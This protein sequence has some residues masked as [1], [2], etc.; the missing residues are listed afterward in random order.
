MQAP[1]RTDARLPVTITPDIW[2]EE[3]E[4]YAPRSPARTAADRERGNLENA[5]VRRTDLLRCDPD[6]ADGTRLGG[7]LKIYVPI[8]DA[9]PSMRP[10]GFVF[11]PVRT[12]QGIQLALIAFGERHPRRPTRSVY[13]RAH[14]RLH[15][16]YPDQ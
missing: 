13:E 5:G 7:L 10:F 6:G 2:R 4:R 14:K 9:P 3:V 1:R 12:D 11:A 16:R 15:G 8:R